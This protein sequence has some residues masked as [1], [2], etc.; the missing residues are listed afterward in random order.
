MGCLEWVSRKQ[1]TD[2][3][4]PVAL[5]VNVLNP[6]INAEAIRPNPE[7]RGQ[8]LKR[9]LTARTLDNTNPIC[10]VV[11]PPE[12]VTAPQR[13]AL[14]QRD[15]GKHRTFTASDKLLPFLNGNRRP[16]RRLQK[17]VIEYEPTPPA[18]PRKR[19]RKEVSASRTCAG[20]SLCIRNDDHR[21]RSIPCQPNHTTRHHAQESLVESNAPV[22]DAAMVPRRGVQIS[23][24]PE[25][26]NSS[27][28]DSV[29]S[30]TR[31]C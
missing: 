4:A 7:K 3:I 5:A 23:S 21:W 2:A 13:G 10:G 20:H 9:R 11:H 15:G 25:R 6:D 14:G 18:H 31:P 12:Y 17:L 27:L 19:I 1:P 29:P 30:L 16:L 24:S 8:P 22:Q 28:A 26:G